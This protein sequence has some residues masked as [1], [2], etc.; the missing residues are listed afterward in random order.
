MAQS[1]EDFA[2]SFGRDAKQVEQELAIAKRKLLAIR[3]RRIHPARDD[4]VLADW[5]GLM[6]DPLARAGVALDVPEYLEAA[7][8]A[9]TMIYEK[10][11]DAEGRLLHCWRD[12]V[13][14]GK[15]FLDDY[16]ALL[17]AWVTLYECT[18]EEVWLDR[19]V[20]LADELQS[21]FEDTEHG[22][23]FFTA[24]DHEELIVRRK[25]FY[26]QATPNGNALAAEGFLRLGSLLG[27][28]AMRITAERALQAASETLCGAPL[29]Q[30]QTVLALLR[31][32]APIRQWVLA[33]RQPSEEVTGILQSLQ[34]TYLPE[35]VLACRLNPAGPQQ[36]L[37]LNDLFTGRPM[38]GQA[39][40]L[41]CCEGF[42][43]QQ[44]A[45][46]ASE[47]RAMIATASHR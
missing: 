12:G 18:F 20:Q 47:A 35:H 34:K 27:R 11:R 29:A 4:K 2:Q 31:H 46:S 22:G 36:S 32:H 19:A 15:A 14:E 44:P 26:D 39:W 8:R 43:C 5:N 7:R 10:M 17:G 6:I 1:L 42:T 37:L 33:A 25:E 16:A 41:Y 23:F 3:D 30:G 45:R 28:D 38:S 13:A 21:R 24:N 40:E 9:S